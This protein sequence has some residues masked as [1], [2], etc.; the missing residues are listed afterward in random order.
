MASQCRPYSAVGHFPRPALTSAI[1]GLRADGDL[2][3]RAERRKPL[4]P[5]EALL[6]PVWHTASFQTCRGTAGPLPRW[7]TGVGRRPGFRFAI[8]AVLCAAVCPLVTQ[9]VCSRGVAVAALASLQTR[10]A[11]WLPVMLWEL[12]R[13]HHF[14][15]HWKK[16]KEQY[17]GIL[18]S[19][20]YQSHVCFWTPRPAAG[21][22]CVWPPCSNTP[23]N[24][25]KQT[26]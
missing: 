26:T 24:I 18:F 8:V 10:F 6:T 25:H 11:P 20:I 21:E 7:L 23:L 9:L 12:P 22:V 17:G 14:P 2:H 1:N 5:G 4:A 3:M 16:T 13:T 19:N 15:L